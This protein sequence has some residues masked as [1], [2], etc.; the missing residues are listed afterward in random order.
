[1]RS[2]D[3]KTTGE[4]TERGRGG[5]MCLPDLTLEADVLDLVALPLCWFVYWFSA[6]SLWALYWFQFL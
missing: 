6:G 3:A 2:G 4:K 1:M 5:D